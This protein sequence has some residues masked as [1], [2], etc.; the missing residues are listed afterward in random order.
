MIKV[1][2]DDTTGAIKGYYPDNIPYASIPEPYIEIDETAHQDCI[3]NQ[4]SRKIDITERKIVEYT[5][6]IETQVAAVETV[7]PNILAFAEALA[8]Q[9]ARLTKLENSTDIEGSTTK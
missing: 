5:P 4:G 3:N 9:E 1:N 8:E 6:T 7:D 2:Y